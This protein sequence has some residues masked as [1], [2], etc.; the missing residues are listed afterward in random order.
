MAILEKG[1]GLDYAIKYKNGEIKKGL[2][3]GCSITDKFVRFKPGQMV[4]VSGFPN[5]F[6]IQL[7]CP[8]VHC[9]CCF[10]SLAMGGVPCLGA[11]D[12]FQL[13]QSRPF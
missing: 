2:G 5:V 12:N 8:L 3:I 11:A 4:V 1:Y 9:S 13:V 7:T 6:P 10:L